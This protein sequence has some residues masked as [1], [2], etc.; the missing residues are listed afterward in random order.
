[1]VVT[2]FNQTLEFASLQS[3][4]TAFNWSVKINI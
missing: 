2:M 1:M 4:K 3:E